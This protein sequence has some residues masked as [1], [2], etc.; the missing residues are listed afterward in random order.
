MPDPDSLRKKYPG[1]S[2]A[3]KQNN[4]QDSTEK[5]KRANHVAT[6]KKI[7]KQS[8]IKRLGKSIIEDSI[9]SVKEQAFNDII[10][11]GI[12]TLIF[13]TCVDMLDA[14]LFRN[15]EMPSRGYRSYSKARRPDR[16]SYSSYWR[17]RDYRESHRGYGDDREYSRFSDVDPDDLIFNTRMEAR[18]VLKE[19]EDYIQVYGEAPIAALYDAAGMTSSD[20]TDNDYGWRSLRGAQIRH[21]REGYLLVLPPT[22]EL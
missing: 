22:Q 15:S 11:P 7:R 17:E 5:P 2:Y 1:N 4:T 10:V 6:P 3:S 16:T 21:T 9:E 20:F 19:V 12:K 18:R 8:M 14:M 13:D